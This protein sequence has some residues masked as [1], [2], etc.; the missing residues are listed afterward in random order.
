MRQ[1]VVGTLVCS[2]SGTRKKMLSQSRLNLPEGIA[3]E[4]RRRIESVQNGE[5]GEISPDGGA[6]AVNGGP[7]YTLFL[8]PDGDAYVEE[9]E[10]DETPPVTKRDR[11]TQILALLLGSRL[12]PEL[13][14][15]LPTR[16]PATPDCD[17]CSGTGRILPIK[18][19]C[20]E[21]HGLGWV[22]SE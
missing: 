16:P 19:I 14:S 8:S 10:L 18:L 15:V 20:G 4:I 9:Y 1:V 13:A 5:P 11:G 21:C 3:A 17:R 7:G 22:E 6:F 12:I 2:S